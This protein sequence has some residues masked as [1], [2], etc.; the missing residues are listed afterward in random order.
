MFS[1][2]KKKC[3]KKKREERKVAK[4]KERVEKDCERIV[5]DQFVY[6]HVLKVYHIKL[7][8][9]LAIRVWCKILVGFDRNTC[10]PIIFL[11]CINSEISLRVSVIHLYLSY[12]VVSTRQSTSSLDYYLTLQQLEF[13]L[14]S[15][16]ITPHQAPHTS[17]R[18]RYSGLVFA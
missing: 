12:L 9:Q 7:C 8:N 11:V 16:C 1:S 10:I 14:H 13:R 5:E 15:L 2:I 3:V 6:V 17:H 18:N 4:K